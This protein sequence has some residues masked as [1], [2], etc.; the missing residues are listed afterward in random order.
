MKIIKEYQASS[1]GK[2][3]KAQKEDA[4]SQRGRIFKNC[5]FFGRGIGVVDRRNA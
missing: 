4:G 3:K 2:K 1:K 5:F